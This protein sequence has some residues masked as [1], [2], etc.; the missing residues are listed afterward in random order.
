MRGA[1]Y[2][3]L[4]RDWRCSLWCNSTSLGKS[5]GVNLEVILYIMYICALYL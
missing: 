4:C 3:G 1:N 2:A 5:V